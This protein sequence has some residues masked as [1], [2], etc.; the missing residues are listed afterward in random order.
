MPTPAPICTPE[1]PAPA[2]TSLTLNAWNRAYQHP[3]TD[4]R[5]IDEVHG[6]IR[7]TCRNC[8]QTYVSEGSDA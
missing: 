3:D 1:S 6:D 5:E 2:S 8:G 4:E 7:Y